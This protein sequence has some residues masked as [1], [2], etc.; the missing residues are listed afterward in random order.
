MTIYKKWGFVLNKAKKI[1]KDKDIIKNFYRPQLYS[2]EPKLWQYSAKIADL[3]RK[4]DAHWDA[5]FGGG[6]S[7]IKTRA[8]IKTIGEA[9]ERYCLGLYKEKDLLYASYNRI[10]DK[11]LPLDKIISFSQSQLKRKEFADCRWTKRDKFFW[12]EGY[13]IFERKSIFLLS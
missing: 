9:V 1:I 12:T 3:T 6:A 10:K 5:G 11:S 2:D 8:M 13:S 4:S 7:F